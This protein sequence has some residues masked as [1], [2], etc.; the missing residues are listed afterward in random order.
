MEE[1]MRRLELQTIQTMEMYHAAC[2]EA[3][4]EKQKVKN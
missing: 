2:K 3:L 1:K 4:R